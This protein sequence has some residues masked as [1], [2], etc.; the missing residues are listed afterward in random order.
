VEQCHDV[1]VPSFGEVSELV[2]PCLAIPDDDAFEPHLVV[3][4]AW[5]RLIGLRGSLREAMHAEESAAMGF[6][7]R[8]SMSEA[9]FPL[10][11]WYRFAGLMHDEA[12]FARAES[13]RE[14]ANSLGA[15]EGEGWA[16]VELARARSA[17]VGGFGSATTWSA[18]LETLALAPRSSSRV[19]AADLRT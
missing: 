1:G 15:L 9:S 10:S 2:A 8:F 12:A 4:G 6:A 11:A 5:G 18:V 14:D 7:C 16:H 17:L 13:F 3:R 19:G